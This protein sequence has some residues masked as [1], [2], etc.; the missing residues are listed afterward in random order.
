[1]LPVARLAVRRTVARTLATTQAVQGH[2][3]SLNAEQ[4]HEAWVEYFDNAD[5]WDLRRGL[6][7]MMTDDAIPT[8]EIMQ[9]TFFLDF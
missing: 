3:V 4:I 6:R 1:M 2:K 8:P 9:V 7:E 5:Y